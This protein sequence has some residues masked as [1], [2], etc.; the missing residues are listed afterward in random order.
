M[1]V[2]QN[3]GSR[4]LNYLKDSEARKAMPM[5]IGRFSLIFNATTSIGEVLHNTL[6]QHTLCDVIYIYIY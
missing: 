3:R 1:C 4:V 5:M 6:P 2:M